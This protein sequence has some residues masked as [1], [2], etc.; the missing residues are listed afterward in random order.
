[1]EISPQARGFSEIHEV[2]ETEEMRKKFQQ[3]VEDNKIV[4]QPKEPVEFA[5][6]TGSEAVLR[7][8]QDDLRKAGYRKLR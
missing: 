2:E 1:M 7:A 6:V 3:L 8:L 5:T 4:N